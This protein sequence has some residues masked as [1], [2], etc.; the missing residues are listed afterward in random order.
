[1]EGQAGGNGCQ[2]TRIR[3]GIQQG[4]TTSLALT[5]DE[6]GRHLRRPFFI[7]KTL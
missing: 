4:L 6:Q 2:K 5:F 7:L 1:V 3:R